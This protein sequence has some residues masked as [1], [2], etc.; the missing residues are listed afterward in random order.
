MFPSSLFCQGS[1]SLSPLLPFLACFP[2]SSSLVWI[3]LRNASHSDSCFFLQESGWLTSSF[4][5]EHKCCRG[6]CHQW[7]DEV[8]GKGHLL[9][10]HLIHGIKP[11]TSNIFMLSSLCIPIFILLSVNYIQS[12]VCTPCIYHTLKWL[13]FSQLILYIYLKYSLLSGINNQGY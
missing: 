5:G 11:L 12:I 2:L 4:G 7:R 8:W 13:P 9:P 3:S 1:C 10:H 6:W